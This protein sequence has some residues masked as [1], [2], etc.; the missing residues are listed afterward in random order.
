[1]IVDRSNAQ[2]KVDLYFNGDD[3]FAPFQRRRDLPIGNL[4]SQF[5]ANLYLD[6]FDHFATEVLGAPSCAASTMSR[7]STIT[8]PC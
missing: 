5:F 6:G 7:C 8:P 3:L 1:M 4:T 2:E